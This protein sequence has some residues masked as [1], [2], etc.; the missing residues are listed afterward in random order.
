M[1]EIIFPPTTGGGGGG[2]TPVVD[3]RDMGAWQV[4]GS[5]QTVQALSQSYDAGTYHVQAVAHVRTG[6]GGTGGFS[7]SQ[8]LLCISLTGSI[9][10]TPNTHLA[11]QGY[12]FSPGGYA[13]S[14][15][16]F[17]GCINA[18]RYITLGATTPVY[19]MVSGPSLSSGDIQVKCAM[20]VTKIA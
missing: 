3:F 13:G 6:D 2:I 12:L 1:A 17:M 15:N 8:M 5:S 7:A 9:D 4:I 16:V 10:V 20:Y 18:V 19:L 14:P 11:C